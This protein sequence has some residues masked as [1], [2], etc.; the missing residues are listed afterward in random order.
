MVTFGEM[1]NLLEIQN[2]EEQKNM[3]R[4]RCFTYIKI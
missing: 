4:N 3:V 1:V 2:I